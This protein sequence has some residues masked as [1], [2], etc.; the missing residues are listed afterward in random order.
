MEFHEKL[1]RLR[2]QKGLTQEELAQALYVSRT[3]ISKWESGRGYPSIDSLKAIAKFFSVTID[4][5]LSGG[6]AVIIAE[7][8]RRQAKRSSLDMM[9]GL[10][11]CSAALFFFMPFFGR[12]MGDRAE[13]VSLFTLHGISA[14]LKSAY[15]GVVVVMVFW[16]IAALALQNCRN[17]LWIRHKSSVSLLLSAVG[18]GLFAIGRQPYAAAFAL[19]FLLIKVWMLL[20]QR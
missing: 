5:L 15:S 17:A 7:E 11:D 9:F 14:Y 19:V 10:L 18:V 8:E 1:Q 6:E 2:K 12:N 16:G 20:K 3:A 13:A 4:E